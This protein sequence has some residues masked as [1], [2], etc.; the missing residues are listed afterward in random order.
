MNKPNARSDISSRGL[1]LL[2]TLVLLLVLGILAA[3]ATRLTN[4][5]ALL[6]RQHQQHSV[7]QQSAQNLANYLLADSNY[8]IEYSK[9]MDS[10]G[11]FTGTIPNNLWSRDTET[12]I[13][14]QVVAISCAAEKTSNGCSADNVGQCYAT[15]YWELTVLAIDR[16]SLAEAKITQGLKF[17][18]LP[19]FCP[20]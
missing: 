12:A 8:F 20:S 17:D 6:I 1:V 18:Y 14:S 4:L 3:G 11:H 7:V 19:G 15:Y 10:D 5:S 9:T 16:L 2:T 13:E